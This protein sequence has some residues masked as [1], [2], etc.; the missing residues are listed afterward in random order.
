MTEVMPCGCQG[1]I[2]L[3]LDHQGGLVKVNCLFGFVLCNAYES[4]RLVEHSY[5]LILNA[6][7]CPHVYYVRRYMSQI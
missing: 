1:A 3:P 5:N 2:S 4:L 6:G 7:Q